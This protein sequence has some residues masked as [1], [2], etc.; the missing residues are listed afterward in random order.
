MKNIVGLLK[1]ITEYSEEIGCTH[2][3]VFCLNAD[4][5]A[6]IQSNPRIMDTLGMSVFPLFRGCFLGSRNVWTIYR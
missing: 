3:L 5:I 6:I 1:L 2:T 4:Y